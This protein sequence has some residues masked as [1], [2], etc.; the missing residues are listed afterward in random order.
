MKRTFDADEFDQYASVDDAPPAKKQR[1]SIQLQHEQKESYY[2]CEKCGSRYSEQEVDDGA[3]KYCDE[4]C[5]EC[6]KDN[7]CWPD[8]GMHCSQCDVFSCMDCGLVS[9]CEKCLEMYCNDCGKFVE[10][11]D[12]SG[13]KE[14]IGYC[15]QTWREKKQREEKIEKCKSWVVCH[16]GSK[17]SNLGACVDLCCGT[18]F[19]LQCP[20]KIKCSKCKRGIYVCNKHLDMVQCQKCYTIR[21][22]KCKCDC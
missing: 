14:K 11:R 20:A 2:N 5:D 7:D 9:I 17:T 13:Y 12:R 22:Q 4:C 19:C 8:H 6:C 16:C 18:L 21:C 1:H 10:K 15:C 3:I